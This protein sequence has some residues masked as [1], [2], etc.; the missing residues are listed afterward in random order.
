MYFTKNEILFPIWTEESDE[1]RQK[2][3]YSKEH[4]NRDKNYKPCLIL[5]LVINFG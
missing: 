2:F 3:N 4:L 5:L 1:L